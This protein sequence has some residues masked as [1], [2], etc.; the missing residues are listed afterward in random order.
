[1]MPNLNEFRAEIERRLKAAREKV[2]AAETDIRAANDRYK[3]ADHQ[4]R[5][6]ELVLEGLQQ[7]AEEP[8]DL[9]L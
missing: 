3:A 2:A 4:R 6:C 8:S 5:Q 1:M 7:L 9:P